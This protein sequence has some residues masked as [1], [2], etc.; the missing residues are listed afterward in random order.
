MSLTNFL[1]RVLVKSA[2]ELRETLADPKKL[3]AAADY[4]GIRLDWAREYIAREI[5]AKTSGRYAT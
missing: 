2:A 4:Y 3:E 5:S 1:K